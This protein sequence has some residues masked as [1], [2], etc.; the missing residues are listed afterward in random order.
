M[1]NKLVIDCY[2]PRLRGIDLCVRGDVIAVDLDFL[3]GYLP[4]RGGNRNCS[5]CFC[6]YD[7]GR[8]MNSSFE[9]A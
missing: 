1:Q 4:R 2:P 6:G 5:T 7:W 3:E 8:G 9:T